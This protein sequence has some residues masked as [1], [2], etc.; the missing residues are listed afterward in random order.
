VLGDTILGMTQLTVSDAGARY[1]EE[2]ARDCERVLGAGV[3]LERLEVEVDEDVVLHLHYRLGSVTG[4]SDGRGADLLAAH[5]DL[6]Q[7]L[8]EDRLTLGFQ[9]LVF[10]R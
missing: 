5:V 7:R 4:A 1:L 6:R 2:I 9:A 3:E 10:G 8:V